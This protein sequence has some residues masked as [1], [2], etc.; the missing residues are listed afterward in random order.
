MCTFPVMYYTV[1]N[2]TFTILLRL[3]FLVNSRYVAIQF[4]S[5]SKFIFLSFHF[6]FDPASATDKENP[7]FSGSLTQQK[8]YQ[9]CKY[10]FIQTTGHF[11]TTASSICNNKDIILN[12]TP[13]IK[14]PHL[15]NI[16]LYT[17]ISV[18]H[19]PKSSRTLSQHNTS[20]SAFNSTIEYNFVG[21]YN[22]FHRPFC[23]FRI[24]TC[25]S[26]RLRVLLQRATENS[27]Q[28]HK[29]TISAFSAEH[30]I[31]DHVNFI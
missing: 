31:D 20:F 5:S 18:R 13:P 28:M 16:D 14:N 15:T 30:N 11:F 19:L 7:L 24:S 23:K 25:M 8:H 22:N 21:I 27:R 1:T 4:C 2:R 3:S 10:A 12:S 26:K 9:Y 17:S 29:A 6:S